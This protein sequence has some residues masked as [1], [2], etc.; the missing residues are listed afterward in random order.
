MEQNKEFDQIK[1]IDFGTSLVM[2]D[3]QTLDEKLGTPYYI[4]PEV[5]A[6][7]Y[8][9]KCDIWS[10]GVITYIILS[11]IPPFNGASDQEIMK[12]VK[13][14]K[15]SFSDPVWASISDQGKDFI[16]Q[17]LTKD[18]DKRPSAESA[19][20][21]PWIQQAADK[22][23]EGVSKESGMAA[24]SNLGKFNAQSKLKQA[25]FA[26]IASQLLSKQER[27]SID[28]VFRAMDTN[29]DGKLDKK[30]IKNGYL[31]YF[32]KTMSDEEIDEM[33]DKVDVDGS[34]AIDY[35]EFVVASMN[36]KNL[37]SNNKLQSAFKMFDKDGGGSI[38]TD[39]IKQVLSFGQN[40]EES[41]VNDIIKQ[42][43]A[44]GDGEISFDEFAEMMLKNIQ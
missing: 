5:L 26:F 36:E 13:L 10:C 41:V 28:K 12:K 1:I 3:K 42:V 33:F 19:L 38:S 34:G 8:N 17:L 14:G 21:L 29:G 43:D 22:Q 11:G 18:K 31:E 6:K 24:L 25:T 30:E 23:K 35:S 32:G 16:T 7:A 2:K 27:E 20:Q 4:A 44:N 37:L 9:E 40:L 39:E 15:F